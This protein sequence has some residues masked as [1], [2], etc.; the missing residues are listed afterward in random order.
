M[1]AWVSKLTASDDVIRRCYWCL[2][3]LFA[4]VFGYV[5]QA[6]QLG[7]GDE[8]AIADPA[9]QLA[10]GHRFAI[11]SAGPGSGHDDAYFYQTPL[12]PLFM[13]PWFQLTGRSL[14][15]AHL[16]SLLLAVGGILTVLLYRKK[17]GW[18]FCFVAAAYLAID[19][20][21]AERS[22]II[23]YDHLAIL[24]VLSGFAI[25]VGS[26]DD[27]Q[28]FFRAILAGILIGL[29]TLTNFL[30]CLYLPSVA[31]AVGAREAMDRRWRAIYLSAAGLFLGFLVSI[32][33]WI[34]YAFQHWTAFSDQFLFQIFSHRSRVL[35]F[36]HGEFDKY[37]TYYSRRHLLLLLPVISGGIIAANRSHRRQHVEF[38]ALALCVTLLLTAV[39]GGKSWHQLVVVPSWA[40]LVACA[41]RVVA[42][43]Q[44]NLRSARA[45]VCLAALAAVNGFVMTW[46]RMV[47]EVF[48]KEGKNHIAIVEQWAAGHIPAE[49]RVYGDRRLVFLAQ[50]KNWT[51]VADYG[52]LF[53]TRDDL[54]AEHT[55]PDWIVLKKHQESIP[56]MFRSDEWTL[57]AS[58]T[59]ERSTLDDVISA[60]PWLKKVFYYTEPQ[61]MQIYHRRGEKP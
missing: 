54:I 55:P 25:V 46:G 33:P 38:L 52:A 56:A 45:W 50:E 60:K 53:N 24:L 22:T 23:R 11:P 21:F 32:A 57:V 29:A 28:Q 6:R 19:P 30:F 15:S 7:T 44:I 49:A 39:S 35:G 8:A 47:C 31:V 17:Y 58:R 61:T 20:G 43:N 18:L 48:L 40:L 34:A 14:G 5:G 59:E 37:Y 42:E 51:F 27:D 26:R 10:S 3:I 12:H 13:A 2:A 4:L 41:G 16:F 36:W 9:L 1:R